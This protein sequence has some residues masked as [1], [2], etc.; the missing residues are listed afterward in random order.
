MQG[1]AWSMLLVAGFI[2]VGS[3]VIVQLVH[4]HAKDESLSLDTRQWLYTNFGTV[5]RAMYTMFECTFTASWFR[6]SR[7]LIEE[8]NA[9]VFAVYWVIFIVGV[10]FTLMKVIQGLFLKQTIQVAA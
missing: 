1:L 3:A 4:T 10:N 9:P 2:V 7:R 5:V 8:V 6:Y